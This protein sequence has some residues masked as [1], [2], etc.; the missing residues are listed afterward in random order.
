MEQHESASAVFWRLLPFVYQVT[1]MSCI[2]YLCDK[3]TLF[4]RRHT[5]AVLLTLMERGVV[6]QVPLFVAELQEAAAAEFTVFQTF[7]INRGFMLAFVSSLISFTVLFLDVIYGYLLDQE[8][9]GGSK[10]CPAN[11]SCPQ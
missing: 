6:S 2:V 10:V 1:V 5:S 7:D 8:D 3:C 11:C 4:T 9:K